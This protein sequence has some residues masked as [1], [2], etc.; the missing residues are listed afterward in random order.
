M[1]TD[2]MA[3]PIFEYQFP[4]ILLGN[5]TAG[6]SLLPKYFTEGKFDEGCELTLSTPAAPN[7]CCSN[8]PAPYWSN[9]SFLIFDIRAL[10]RSVLSARA[11]KCQKLKMVGYT[12]MAKCKALTGSAVKGLTVAKPIH[13]LGYL[14]SPSFGEFDEVL[15]AMPAGP[16]SCH[17]V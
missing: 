2:D 9:P 14:W 15:P 13:S 7:C 16:E 3:K 5:S 10:W 8:G 4:V 1:D 6:K 12:S 11:P 17:F